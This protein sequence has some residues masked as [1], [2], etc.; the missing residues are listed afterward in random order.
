MSAIFTCARAT[1]AVVASLSRNESVRKGRKM[2]ENHHHHRSFVGNE[3]FTDRNFRRLC[4]S[5]RGGGGKG[6]EER[7]RRISSVIFL[8]FNRG[9]VGDFSPSSGQ[10]CNWRGRFVFRFET[11]ERVRSIR[12]RR[13][14]VRRRGKS[15]G[16]FRNVRI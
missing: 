1:F 7:R 4:S 11:V 9:R 13:R 2:R 5:S 14:V 3:N 15:S 8:R 10:I 16:V 12:R 6:A